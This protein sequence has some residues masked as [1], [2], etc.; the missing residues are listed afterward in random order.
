MAITTNQRDRAMA[1]RAAM[2]SAGTVL[3]SNPD[4]AIVSKEIYREWIPGN[5][6]LGDVRKQGGNLY[7]CCQAHDSS[8][9]PSW[10]PAMQR[11]LWSP[12]HGTTPETAL[13]FV[14][15]TGAHDMYLKGE[16][17][18]WTDGTVRK[19]TMDTAYSPDEYDRAW[20]TSLIYIN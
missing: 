6:S 15:P 14:H 18:I 13:P 7:K 12:Y 8:A 4:Q 19:A 10:T 1:I 17:M 20:E 11:A 5:Y 2:D 3:A 9:N 16:C